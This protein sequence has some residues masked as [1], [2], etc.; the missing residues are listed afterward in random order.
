MN[1]YELR[2][3]LKSVR[4]NIKQAVEKADRNKNDIKLIPVSK[5]HPLDKI[6]Y[7]YE[8]GFK[9]FGESRVQELRNKN[10]KIENM[11]I[12]WHFIGHLQ[13]NK[14]K[15][16]L[17]MK[18]CTMIESLDSWRLAREIN[19]RA[20]KNDRIMSVLVEVNVSGED[21]KYGIKPENTLNF[22]KKVDKL[23][24]IKIEGLMTLAPYVEDPEKTRPYFQKL[25]EIKEKVNRSG[26]NLKELSMGMSNDYEI[27]IEEGATILRIGTALFGPREN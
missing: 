13:T 18:N 27:A 16:L 23:S 11:D 12:F 5:T 14:V 1:T 20:K 9:T 3:R 19:K 7:F 10:Q 21:S 15:Y 25:A 26:F 2:N 22:I 24:H 4:D 8:K 6:E 17:R